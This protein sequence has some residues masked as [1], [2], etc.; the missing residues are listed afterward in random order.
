[1]SH[2]QAKLLVNQPAGGRWGVVNYD[3]VFAIGD[4]SHPQY[5]AK[6]GRQLA[7]ASFRDIRPHPAVKR[8]HGLWRHRDEEAGAV[9]NLGRREGGHVGFQVIRL[10]WAATGKLRH[11]SALEKPRATGD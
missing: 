4:S 2:G 5:L 3:V 6:E 9:H 10:G 7:E 1:L 11:F 8:L